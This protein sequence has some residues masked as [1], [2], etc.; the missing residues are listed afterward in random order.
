MSMPAQILPAA[1]IGGAT[2]DNR[3]PPMAHHHHRNRHHF[4]FRLRRRFP[5]FST[6]TKIETKKRKKEIN[7]EVTGEESGSRTYGRW[8]E[9][10]DSDARYSRRCVA[11]H[12]RLQCASF[13][14]RAELIGKRAE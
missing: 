8:G 14:S 9:D 5:S 12:I 3:P 4:L 1:E 10:D 7:G 6:R 11:P 13:A 2:M